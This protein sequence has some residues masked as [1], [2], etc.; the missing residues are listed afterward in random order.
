[1]LRT[2]GWTARLHE[3]RRRNIF[4]FLVVHLDYRQTPPKVRIGLTDASHP[5]ICEELPTESEID[6][7]R[8]CIRLV[9]ASQRENNFIWVTIS[10]GGYL[11]QSF[12][13]H[14]GVIILI[15]VRVMNRGGQVR[16]FRS[17]DQL[18]VR[19]WRENRGFFGVPS[20][21]DQLISVATGK[22]TFFWADLSCITSVD[23][24]L[25][26]K[27]SAK[28]ASGKNDFGNQKRRYKR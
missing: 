9:T 15:D 26:Q 22:S 8:K 25:L 2:R 24:R 3:I 10:V 21:H 11:S 5:G 17:H 7:R 23:Q 14:L 19:F 6:A 13:V 20:D 1:M 4:H 28:V 18:Y 16:V 27:R 12:V